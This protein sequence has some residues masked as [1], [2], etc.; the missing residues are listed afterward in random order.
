MAKR[1]FRFALF[2]LAEVWIFSSPDFSCLQ[3]TFVA[4]S[5]CVFRAL[6]VD[7]QGFHV[8]LA[9]IFVAHLGAANSSLAGSKFAIEDV[10]WDA[11]ILH[12]AHMADPLQ[13]ALSEQREHGGKTSALEDLGIRHL[14]TPMDAD[15]AAQEAHVEAVQFTLLFGVCCPCLTAVE[16]S[17]DHAGILHCH[18]CWN[19]Q[20]WVLPDAGGEAS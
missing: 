4:A 7:V 9:D 15:D 13:P 18:L 8:T 19:C 3:K 2:S 1:A 11:P 14:V 5:C 20:L 10:L 12:L 6:R 17:A 16:E